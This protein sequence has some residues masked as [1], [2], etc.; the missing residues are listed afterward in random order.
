MINEPMNTPYTRCCDYLRN[1]TT[2]DELEQFPVKFKDELDWIKQNEPDW[3]GLIR[4][5]YN[6]HRNKL[7][8]VQNEE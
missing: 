6:W 3:V 2:L 5:H 1:C 7:K 8:G 4:L